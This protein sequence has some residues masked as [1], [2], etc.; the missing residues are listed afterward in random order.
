MKKLI[1]SESER[2]SI[3]AQHSKHGYNISEQAA[4][5]NRKK[6][7]QCFL[8]KKGLYKGKIDGLHGTGTEG[9]ITKYQTNAGVYPTDGVWGPETESKMN[10]QDKEIF[11]KCKYEH[12]DL[13]DK[14]VGGVSKFFGLD[15]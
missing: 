9:A 11:K 1:I 6:A 15:K 4:D 3:L 13:M 14:I 5:I 7:I 10:P 12:G 2:N 8:A